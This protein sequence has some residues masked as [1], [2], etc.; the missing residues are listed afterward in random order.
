MTDL[1]NSDFY[2]AAYEPGAEHPA[3]PTWACRGHNPVALDEDWPGKAIQ[4]RDITS[5]PGAFQLTGVLSAEECRRF[6]ELTESLGYLP[7]AAVSLPRDIRHNDN[8]VWVTDEGTDGIIW[9]RIASLV[10]RNL[11]QL[12][13]KPPLGINARFRFYRYREGDYF[14]FHSDG[15]WPGSRVIE[16]KLVANAYP[17]RYS[18]LTLLL[19]LN[20]DFDGGA[21]RF[22]LEPGDKGGQLQSSTSTV[23][24]IRTPA[25]GAL[26]FPHGAHPLHRVH[27]S[28]PIHRGVK[29]VIRSDVLFRL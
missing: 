7:D 10:K 12:N 8:V 19:F 4:R 13:G 5:V 20:D 17:D 21:T 27:S 14:R 24:D 11:T 23:A 28:E 3:L 15:A 22:L 2:V 16:D 26:C 25:G 9:E 6:I 18:Q 1:P 29:Y